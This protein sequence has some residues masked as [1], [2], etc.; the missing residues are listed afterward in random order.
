MNE[1][2]IYAMSQKEEQV[3]HRQYLIDTILNYLG[4]HYDSSRLY[5]MFHDEMGFSDEDIEE[6]GFELSEHRSYEWKD[7]DMRRQYAEQ[8]DDVLPRHDVL[9]TAA[10]IKFA[11]EVSDWEDEEFQKEAELLI[12]A[13]KEISERYSP[14]AVAEV[15]AMVHMAQGI[16]L[17]NEIIAAAEY[18][19]RGM[20]APEL[21]EMAYSGKFESAPFPKL[22]SAN[23]EKHGNQIQMT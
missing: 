15:Y 23:E 1:R 13:F 8:L 18:A 2:N 22:P 4:E 3:S 6:L 7:G 21:S 14:K 12:A 17:A 19:E 16:P 9:T 5:E 10:W 11:E 20:T